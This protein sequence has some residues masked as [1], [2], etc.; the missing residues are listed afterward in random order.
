MKK[1]IITYLLLIVLIISLG[2]FII[3]A[4][5]YYTDEEIKSK[6]TL[7]LD[8][9]K[10]KNLNNNQKDNV[11]ETYYNQKKNI[12][13]VKHIKESDKHVVIYFKDTDWRVITSRDKFWKIANKTNDGG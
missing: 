7:K 11:I 6:K 9:I 4:N 5:K 10:E 8:K 2:S 1:I 12:L 13:K 3:N